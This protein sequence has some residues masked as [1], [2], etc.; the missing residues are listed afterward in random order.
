MPVP[1]GDELSPVRAAIEAGLYLQAWDLARA[2]GRLETWAGAE[3][4][5]LAGRLAMALGAPRLGLSLHV[6]AHRESP[7]HAEALYYRARAELALRGPYGA[8]RFMRQ[9][10]LV[11]G[12][13]PDVRAD[14]AALLASVAAGFRDFDVAERRLAEAEALSPSRPWIAVERTALLEAQD[15]FDEAL[16]LVT[17]MLSASPGYRPGIV[18]SARLLERLG[19][20]EDAVALLQRADAQLESASVSGQLAQILLDLERPEEALAALDRFELLSPLLEPGGRRWLA[21]QRSDA[22]YLLGDLATARHEAEAVATPFYSAIADRLADPAAARTRTLLPVPFLQQ[23]HL[24]CSPTALASLTT[25]WRKPVSPV[26]LATQIAYDGTPGWR[27][28]EWARSAGWHEREFRLTAEAATG[29]IERGVPFTLVTQ[30]ASSAHAQAVAGCDRLRGTLLIRDPSGPR[31]QEVL[32]EPLLEQQAAHG[33]RCL[34]LWPATEEPL[35]GLPDADEF[36]AAHELELALQ[37]H[38][39]DAAQAVRDALAARA[40]DHRLRLHMDARL[41]AYDDDPVAALPAYEA[42]VERYPDCELFA[43]RRIDLLLHLGRRCEAIAALEPWARNRHADPVFAVRLAEALLQDAR[44]EREAIRLLDRA[45]RLRAD[46]ATALSV[47]AD[48]V[49]ARGRSEEAFELRRLAACADGYDEVRVARYVATAQSLGRTAEAVAFLRERVERLGRL[50]SAPARTLS[51]GLEDLGLVEP[52]LEVLESSLALHPADGDL[53]LHAAETHARYGR[54]ERASAL[55]AAAAGRARESDR[56]RTEARL[57][58]WTGDLTG[59]AAAWRAVAETEPLAMDAHLALAGLISQLEDRTAAVRYLRDAAARVPTH[60]GLERLLAEWLRDD[61]AAAEPHLRAALERH[62]TDAWLHRELALVLA[63]QGRFDEARDAAARGA[64]LEPGLPST[65]GVQGLVLAREGRGREA[66]PAFREAIERAIDYGAAVDGLLDAV[67]DASA[68]REALRFVASELIRQRSTD[69]L[70]VY[71]RRSQGVLEPAEVLAALEA[72]RA[73]HPDLWQPLSALADAHLAQGDPEQAA[74]LLDAALQGFPLVGPLWLDRA[75]VAGRQGRAEEEIELLGRAVAVAPGWPLPLRQLGETLVRH[76]RFEE[77]V[78]VLRRALALDPADARATGRLAEALR[79]AGQV[80]PARVAL[81]RAV[82]LAPAYHWAWQTLRELAGEE[83]AL[84]LARRIAEE[85]PHEQAALLALARALPPTALE[86]ALAVLDRALGLDPRSVDAHD[87]R[88]TLLSDAGRTQQ[89]LE[90]CAPT[91]FG[92]APPC[93]LRGRRAWILDGAGRRREAIEVMT[94]VLADYPD[95]LWG[96]GCLTEW[97]AEHGSV[98]EAEAAASAWVRIAPDDAAAW[99]ARGAARQR[100]GDVEGSLSDLRTAL[101]IDPALRE[102]GSRQFEVLLTTGRLDEAQ[103][104]LGLQDAHLTAEQRVCRGVRLLAA[105]GERDEAVNR[106]AAHLREGNAPGPALASAVAAL[107]Q[108]FDAEAAVA[109]VAGSVESIHPEAAGIAVGVVVG[110]AGSIAGERVLRAVESRPEVATSV[111]RSW[112]EESSDAREDRA[113]ARRLRELAPTDAAALAL[114]A[115]AHVEDAPDVRLAFYDEI[116]SLDPTHVEA[117]DLRAV[118][119]SKLGR[120]AEARAACRQVAGEDEVPVALRARLAWLESVAGRFGEAR[121]MMRAVVADHPHHRWAWERLLDWGFEHDSAGRSY[122][123]DAEGYAQAFPGEPVALGFLGDARRRTGQ[124]REAETALRRAIELD[125]GF[126]W[127]RRALADL[128]VAQ[129]RL[130]EADSVLA[131]GGARAALL[132]ARLQVAFSLRDLARARGLFVDLLS[133]GDASDEDLRKARD[134]FVAARAERELR[135]AFETALAAPDPPL[136]AAAGLAQ[137]LSSQRDWRACEELLGRLQAPRLRNAVLEAYVRGLRDAKEQRRL[138][139]LVRDRREILQGDDTVW[140]VV[141]AALWRFDARASVDWM[142]DWPRRTT[143]PWALHVLV[144]SL[145]RLGR[146]EEAL[147]ASRHA[148]QLPPDNCTD[149]HRAWLAVEAALCGDPHEAAALCEGLQL[150]EDSQDFY[151]ALATLAQA[152]LIARREGRV[153]F[154]AARKKVLEADALA[155]RDNV[156]YGPLRRR[157]V[158]VV[159]AARGGLLGRLWRLVA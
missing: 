67:P 120:A 132:G 28:R 110:S 60:V 2:R 146:L 22:R 80:G 21:A 158:A 19:R 70:F 39:R 75:R 121:R 145:R 8:W 152:A 59:S 138:K 45:L 56:R 114:A 20:F 124:L 125:A 55:L 150:P 103:A 112:L 157:A 144:P 66:V 5:V 108:A 7:D 53:L 37:R 91:V 61:P 113:A 9:R 88:A 32:L 12:A 149:C 76:G 92:E 107:V 94:A 126:T 65:L 71:Q 93:E 73:A 43:L 95:Y 10:Q 30:H 74:S 57:A 68:R 78:E 133:T 123:A 109:V 46:Q 159:A 62:P 131:Q 14:W 82:R 23:Q 105:R 129:Q 130:P 142:A 153:G 6:R 137:W 116:L 38:D 31:L 119:L 29:L 64:E 98:A 99:T 104:S 89:A 77:A 11:P 148:L 52:A 54:A 63:D 36:D 4:R 49:A 106:L 85:R 58:R 96:A 1:A 156:D 147:R 127:G 140:A 41:A 134:Q 25:F 69:S 102:A 24:T 33:P 155:G 44:S 15:R 151:R 101:A 84:A 143:T 48:A 154:G 40:P 34:A 18:A 136:L 42:L 50:S 141:G 86:E 35:P 72:V 128:L 79:A 100:A 81:E 13:P 27:E 139:R 117:R 118:M 111:C 51:R 122:L 47:L 17:S 97:T 83:A 90:A 115:R 26:A 16:E 135:E 3:A 87:L